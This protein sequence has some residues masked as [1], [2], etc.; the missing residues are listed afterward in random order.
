[1]K[2][3]C[4]SLYGDIRFTTVVWNLTRRISEICLYISWHRF[5]HFFFVIGSKPVLGSNV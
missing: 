2:K 5:D 3:A 4:D 1:M